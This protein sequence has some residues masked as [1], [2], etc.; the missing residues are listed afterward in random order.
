MVIDVKDL[1]AV[2]KA[3][4]GVGVINHLAYTS[5]DALSGYVGK[6]IVDVDLVGAKGE[7]TRLSPYDYNNTDSDKLNR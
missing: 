1:A 2:D 6:N 3:V 7:F 5:G 4:K